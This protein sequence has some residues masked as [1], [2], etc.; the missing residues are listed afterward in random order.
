M[1]THRAGPP[2]HRAKAPLTTGR[3]A[4]WLGFWLIMALIVMGLVVTLAGKGSA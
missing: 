1:S 2:A 3:L 4:V